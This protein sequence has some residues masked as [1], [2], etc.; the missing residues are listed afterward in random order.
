MGNKTGTGPGA[1]EAE[2]DTDAAAGGNDEIPADAD[3]EGSSGA[4]GADGEESSPRAAGPE[5]AALAAGPARPS[6]RQKLAPLLR[7]LP[8]A[9]IALVISICFGLSFGVNY[10]VDNQAA[11]MLGSL[12]LLDPSVLTKDFY[13]AGAANY[14]PAFAYV[15]WPL[16]AIDRGGAAVGWGL[17][18][19]VTLGAMCMYWL[20]AELLKQRRLALATFLLVMAIAF[21]TRTRSVAVTFIFDFILQPSTLGSLFLLAALPPFVAG[22]YLLS[23]VFLGLSGLFH[24]NYLILGIGTFGLTQLLLGWRDGWKD[25]ARRIAMQVGPAIA[26]FLLL[27]PLILSS[28]RSPDAALAHEILFN[29]RSPHHYAPTTF[30]GRFFPVA[31]WQMLGLGAGAWLLRGREGRGRRFGAAVL[32]LAILIWTGT[33]LTTWVQIPRVAQ[34]FV[35]RFAPFLDLLMQMLVCAAS[36]SIAA[37]P[38]LLRRIPTAGLTLTLGG[39]VALAMLDNEGDLARA[40]WLVLAPGAAGAL[41][42]AAASLLERRRVRLAPARA[43]LLRFGAYAVVAYAA[44]ACLH[45][46][47][48]AVKSYRER[49]NV[50][51]GM[52][53]PEDDM[54]AW[55]RANTS[56]DALFLTPPQLAR[57]RLIGERA[58]VV[59]W[60]ASTYVPSELVEWYRRL[61]DVS[62]RKGFRSAKELFNGYGRLDAARLDS[63]QKKYKF[64]Y[65][66]VARGRE[67]NLPGKVVYKNS[68]FVI[69][70]LAG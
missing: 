16:L 63:L 19:T 65:V 69:L 70:S 37:R 40:L 52:R 50:I 49:S 23:G 5:A 30:K 32:A 45:F 13:A 1:P 47:V 57:F 54:Y 42:G 60:K 3:G 25:L 18:V 11:Y 27:S 39:F 59:D 35:W 21:V 10:G 24:A 9:L 64:N 34:V 33:L 2:A 28:V 38:S 29:I 68:R 43:L 36:A 15:G 58:I 67:R 22:R 53:G 4:E 8:A 48:P 51:K 41:I 56:K 66:V 20:A 17:V 61:E 46:A 62:G 26:V 55:I 7:E 12:R 6:P 14:H 31:A 44:F